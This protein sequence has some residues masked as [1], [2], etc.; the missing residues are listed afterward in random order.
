MA[1][2]VMPCMQGDKF[3]QQQNAR[4]D[5]PE[6]SRSVGPQLDP[7][8]FMAQM[9]AM[10]SGMENR[11][12]VLEQ[13]TYSAERAASEVRQARH[14]SGAMHRCGAMHQAPCIRR[15]ASSARA[16]MSFQTCT[17]PVCAA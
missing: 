8:P 1:L 3:Q 5:L 10:S 14:A 13:R 9:Q 15:H 7:L 6:V 11:L 17:T 4:F 16:H 2:C 12:A